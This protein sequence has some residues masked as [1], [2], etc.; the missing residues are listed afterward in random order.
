MSLTSRRRFLKTAAFLPLAA[1][2]ALQVPRTAAA[3][4]AP[5]HRVGGSKIKISLNA[6]SFAKLLNNGL[7]RGPGGISLL[8]LAEF[9]AKHDFDAIDPTAYYFP[10]YAE[11]KPPS[12]K[13]IFE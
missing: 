12:D 11:R 13:F 4:V 7:G 10:G 2:A 8:E 3:A 1:S 5:P 9:C 6:Y